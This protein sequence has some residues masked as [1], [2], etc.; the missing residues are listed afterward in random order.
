M[1]I[2][3]DSIRPKLVQRCMLAVFC[4]SGASESAWTVA[5]T[6]PWERR[7]NDQNN[8]ADKKEDAKRFAEL[9]KKA[10]KKN[11]G[12]SILSKK[13]IHG[14]YARQDYRT[15]NARVARQ[16]RAN[17]LPKHRPSV[18]SSPASLLGPLSLGPSYGALMFQNSMNLWPEWGGGALPWNGTIGARYL[19]SSGPLVIPYDLALQNRVQMTTITD[20]YGNQVVILKDIAT[21]FSQQYSIIGRLDSVHAPGAGNPVYGRGYTVSAYTGQ[22]LGTNT[23]SMPGVYVPALPYQ[24]TFGYPGDLDTLGPYGRGNTPLNQPGLPPNPFS[25]YDTTSGVTFP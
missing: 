25:G 23:S 21:G 17:F 20:S 15:V 22:I 24:T 3:R 10:R 6:V 7:P 4:I 9:L 16:I 1:N 2:F 18:V 12:K 14:I 19:L 11:P 8:S 13:D 5:Q